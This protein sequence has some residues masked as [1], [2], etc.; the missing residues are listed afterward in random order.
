LEQF[1]VLKHQTHEPS[2]KG[3]MTRVSTYIGQVGASSIDLTTSDATVTGCT[4]WLA[5]HYDENGKWQDE[6]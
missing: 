6:P 3:E 5:D 4:C 2:C 1:A